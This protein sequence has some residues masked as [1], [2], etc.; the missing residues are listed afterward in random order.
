MLEATVRRVV[1]IDVAKTSH[2]VCALAAPS[3]AVL[4][5]GLKI[6]A[7]AEG[8]RQL[9]GHLERWGPPAEVLVGVEATGCL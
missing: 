5:K 8:Y 4:Q 1:G 7:T 3:G 2:V 9:R 6:D